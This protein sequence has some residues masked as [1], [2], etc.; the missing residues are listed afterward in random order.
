MTRARED[1][2][3]VSTIPPLGAEVSAAPFSGLFMRPNLASQGEVPASTPFCS[4]PDIWPS[5]TQPIPDYVNLLAGNDP[6]YGYEH[7]SWLS[8]TLFRDNYIYVRTKNGTSTTKSKFVSLYYAPSASVQWPAN[9][10]DNVLLTDNEDS[11]SS[12]KNV[13][14][15]AVGVAERPFVWPRVPESSVGEHYCLIAQINDVENSNPIPDVTSP[16]DM[17][18][19]VQNNL[20]WGWRNVQTVDS[21]APKWQ[22]RE[23][24]NIPQNM[25]DRHYYT[26]NL[27]CIGYEGWKAQL[28]CSQAD[29][30]GNQIEIKPTV[31]PQNDF[32]LYAPATL[33]PGFQGLLTISMYNPNNITPAPGACVR[34]EPGYPTGNRA[35]AEAAVRS[36][37]V[38]WRLSRLLNDHAPT[39][40]GI[41]PQPVVP[42]GGNTYGQKR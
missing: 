38:D 18:A 6:V 42:I 30:L 23:L 13:M 40:S 20:G 41:T 22:I 12:L 31:I 36:G 2:D 8:V 37:L 16:L 33:D 17:A 9:W 1:L 14:A 7:S 24:L 35:Q 15:G 3:Q 4:S 21:G 34:T 26:L 29:A 19:L 27:R 25:R 39:G 28:Q 32:G 5:G 10:Q 11:H